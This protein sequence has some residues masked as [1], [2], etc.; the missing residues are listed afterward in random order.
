[1]EN[2]IIRK[3]SVKALASKPSI[4][5][6]P[7]DETL[8]LEPAIRFCELEDGDDTEEGE[9][10]EI[11]VIHNSSLAASKQAPIW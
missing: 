1:M 2:T 8:G 9:E 6:L 5:P 4:K 11:M 10:S 7:R 3:S